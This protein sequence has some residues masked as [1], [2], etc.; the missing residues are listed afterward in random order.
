[1]AKLVFEYAEDHEFG[2]TGWRLENKPEFNAAT[3]GRLVAHDCIEHFA[4][5][6]GSVEAE[7]MALGAA[8]YGRCNMGQDVTTEGLASDM[9][10][11]CRDGVRS[12]GRTQKIE[13]E[14]ALEEMS[15]KFLQYADGEEIINP[16]KTLANALGWI[17]KGY[18]KAAKRYFSSL[19]MVEMFN[20]IERFV[21]NIR[22]AELGEKLIIQ[23]F[24][25]LGEVKC[26][27]V[28]IEDLYPMED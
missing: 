14:W 24:P 27:H 25:M 26:K 28:T 15:E 8:L 7:L 13:D 16:A 11:T 1:M 18:R 6:D 17:R 3:D 23:T 12:P 2:N 9:L 20:D 5:D 21:N 19:R 4:N 22:Y 10:F